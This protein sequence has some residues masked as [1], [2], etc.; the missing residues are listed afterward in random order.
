M[1]KSW[2]CRVPADHIVRASIAMTRVANGRS[3]LAPALMVVA[4]GATC[5]GF[6]GPGSPRAA[7]VHIG[8]QSIPPPTAYVVNGGSDNVT[9]ITL[10]TNKP[11]PPISVQH[12]PTNV[13]VSQN[14]E[15]AYVANDVEGDSYGT[16]TLIKTATNTPESSM[17]IGG[18]PLTMAITP[19]R[20]TIYVTADPPAQVTVIK[21]NTGGAS[22]ST[23]N[24]GANPNK[25]G[26]TPD[27]KTAYVG[28]NLLNGEF[29][30]VPVNV[31]T[32]SSGQPI[33]IGAATADGIAV[34][35][36]TT[37]VL[38]D[39]DVVTPIS[40]ATNA[41]GPPI[42]VPGSFP[43]SIAV[44]PDGS[45]VYVAN[46]NDNT[47]TGGTVTP[48]NTITN[49]PGPAIKVGKDPYPIVMS[50]NG[51]VLYVCNAGDT[52]TPIN[53]QTNK[54]GKPIKVGNGPDAI[55]FSP[56]GKTAYVADG[57]GGTVTPFNVATG[58]PGKPIKV[59]IGP[60]AIAIA[61]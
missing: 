45:T 28:A 52:V 8:V 3:R 24:V 11:G 37:Y 51:K 47:S 22:V 18:G 34:S 19:D 39:A 53:T 44:T 4:I 54:A 33:S 13:V 49:T 5:T 41:P 42:Q 48:I 12:A 31:A 7:R 27:S 6:S 16:V 35:P 23:V 17:T 50:P 40:T 2:F 57:T 1:A 56:T 60:V 46:G 38:N 32:N 10:A 59:G 58:I 9:P 55:A 61:P 25:I 29:T 20:D 21:A 14:G 26:F 43:S 15:F 36:T 30:V